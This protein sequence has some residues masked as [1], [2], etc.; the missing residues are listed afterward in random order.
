MS[1]STK[2][3]PILDE[4]STI[5]DIKDG[6]VYK[7][8][9]L[10]FKKTG[11]VFSQIAITHSLVIKKPIYVWI[12]NFHRHIIQDQHE[13]T[14]R[15]ASKEEKNVITLLNKFPEFKIIYNI[16]SEYAHFLMVHKLQYQRIK[17]ASDIRIPQSRFIFLIEHSHFFT[18]KL[19]PIIINEKINGTPL[20]DMFDQ[21][22][23]CIKSQYLQFL[24]LIN[25]VLRNLIKST[26]RNHFNWYIGNFLYD[27]NTK[28]MSYVDP[29]PSCIF[30]LRENEQNIQG[31]GKIF[32]ESE[33][34]KSTPNIK[35]ELLHMIA[36]NECKVNP[37]GGYD[38]VQ[39]SSV[40]MVSEYGKFSQICGVQVAIISPLKAEKLWCKFEVLFNSNSI[41]TFTCELNKDTC[42][43]TRYSKAEIWA[44]DQVLSFD[45]KEG[46][47]YNIIL[48]LSISNVSNSFIESFGRSS[49]YIGDSD[50]LSIK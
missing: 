46:G 13:N 30:M 42:S 43:Q 26:F 12:R 47:L 14:V 4:L 36:Y 50:H 21:D 27:L 7:F 48:Y 49:I 40:R 25:P 18:N 41:A 16:N 23:S 44:W 20:I 1:L 39:A 9:R 3:L 8:N 17:K 37:S 34:Y 38:L 5:T 33:K 24:Q 29:K 15:P 2:P 10:K 6:E 22:R 31:L 11:N 35:A 19:Y 45:V 28:I 32:F